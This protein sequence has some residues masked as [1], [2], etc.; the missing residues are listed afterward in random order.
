MGLA[1]AVGVA[2]FWAVNKWV[3]P[4]IGGGV[5]TNGDDDGEDDEDAD[6]GE[7]ADDGA[8]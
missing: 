3:M 4:M 7:D 6:V 2:G 1:L 8:E 5:R